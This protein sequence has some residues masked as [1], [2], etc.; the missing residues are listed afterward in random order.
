LAKPTGDAGAA[1]GAASFFFDDAEY[2][3]VAGAASVAEAE[4]AATNLRV[5]GAE[6]KLFETTRAEPERFALAV[7]PLSFAD[8]QGL[9]WQL[10]KGGSP[11]RV[12]LGEEFVEPGRVL[13]AE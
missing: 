3:E 2:V 11:A 13:S 12:S 4:R 5:R 7:G 1:L 6:L 9:R 8:A 10:L